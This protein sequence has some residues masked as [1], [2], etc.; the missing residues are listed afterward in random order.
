[1]KAFGKLCISLGII[2]AMIAG[3]WY[4]YN[5]IDDQRAGHESQ[6]AVEEIQLAIDVYKEY[7]AWKMEPSATT[8]PE[9]PY[10]VIEGHKYIGY[11]DI[12]DLLLTLPV[13]SEESEDKLKVS[14]CRYSGSIAGG[15]M[16]IAG[17]NYKRHFTPIKSLPIGTMVFFEDINGVRTAYTVYKLEDID[18]NDAKSMLAGSEEWDLTLFT[19]SYGGKSRITLRC[20]EVV[21]DSNE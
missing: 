9:M 19:C 7:S 17:H 10:I 14:P 21:A 20:R 1:M 16:I 5:E 18:G 3:G 13:Q 11:I 12:P 2:L 8:S 15:N 4:L 6:I